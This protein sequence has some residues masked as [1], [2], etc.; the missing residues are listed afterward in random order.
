MLVADA[1]CKVDTFKV[2]FI[3]WMSIFVLGF[4]N[5]YALDTYG[6]TTMISA[7]S[8]N[9]IWMGLNAAG[10][11]W[12]S[13]GENLGLFFGFIIGA[14][15]ALYTQNIFKNNAKQFIFNWTIF[16]L[17][18]VLY[19][20]CLQ[21]VIPAYAA[22]FIL[23][24]VSGAALG[25]FRKMYHLEINN[26]MATGSVRFLGLHFAGGFLK[27][28]PKEVL[29]FWIFVL[30][31]LAFAGGAF[32]Y[33]MLAKLDYSLGEAGKLLGL[34]FVDAERNGRLTLGLGL[35]TREG[36]HGTNAMRAIH[37]NI[38]R[39][40]GLIAISVIPYF[41]CPKNQNAAQ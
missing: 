40:I 6:L 18:I 13:L 41:F 9:V 38:A 17:P 32:L 35:A 25:F 22:M 24:F 31:V 1:N 39:I 19:P 15:F 10:G 23:G 5:G 36:Y 14:M 21:Y 2:A 30:C 27:K 33:A 12:G 34:G 3:T 8:G 28:N 37:S 4:L 7:Q 20:F 11:Y 29:S 16:V 26:A